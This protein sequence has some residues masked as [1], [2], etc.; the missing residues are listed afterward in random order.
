M[1]A[2]LTQFMTTFRDVI[3]LMLLFQ[4]SAGDKDEWCRRCM[5]IN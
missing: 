1:L 4:E 5:G 2:L 3:I